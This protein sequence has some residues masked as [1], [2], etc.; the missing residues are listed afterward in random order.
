MLVPRQ[1]LEPIAYCTVV[2]VPRDHC[3]HVT[4][5]ECPFCGQPHYHGGGSLSEPP[6]LGLRVG[7][8][9]TGADRSY[10][11]VLRAAEPGLEPA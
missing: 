1:A 11:L 7:H 6:N 8:C 3:W 9:A 2:P 4:V 5:A 10:R